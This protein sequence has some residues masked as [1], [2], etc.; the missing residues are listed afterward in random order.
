MEK[1]PLGRSVINL[2]FNENDKK[3]HMFIIIV[4]KYECSNNG[5]AYGRKKI[6]I[7]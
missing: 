1:L 6:K 7:N 3:N 4:S 5:T 2:V